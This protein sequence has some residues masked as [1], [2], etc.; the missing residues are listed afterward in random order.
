MPKPY[1]KEFREDVVR[2]ARKRE[3]GVT[4]ELKCEA[5][6]KTSTDTWLRCRR[7]AGLP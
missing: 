7:T 2:V 6:R 3:S 5:G 4:L 1:P